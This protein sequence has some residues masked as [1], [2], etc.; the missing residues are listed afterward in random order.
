MRNRNGLDN[1]RDEDQDNHRNPK[2]S[3]LTP[4]AITSEPDPLKSLNSLNLDLNPKSWHVSGNE[5]T[6]GSFCLRTK[7]GLKA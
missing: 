3:T 4:E 1:D 5:L 2:P 7:T 6:K